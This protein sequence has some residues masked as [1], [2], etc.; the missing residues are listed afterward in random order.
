MAYLS[1]ELH[2]FILLVSYAAVLCLVTQRNVTQRSP[3]RTWGGTL[4]DETKNGCVGDYHF[5]PLERIVTAFF[6]KL[7]LP[8]VVLL[9][10]SVSFISIL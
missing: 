6:E 9:S 1:V 8:K 4:R 5:T 2:S 7:N 3:P 10:L